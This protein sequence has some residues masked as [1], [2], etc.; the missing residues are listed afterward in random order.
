MT[1]IIYIFLFR[2][3]RM[4]RSA[5]A[6][7]LLRDAHT[8]TSVINAERARVLF[9]T[10]L[11]RNTRCELDRNV[12]V[13]KDVMHCGQTLPARQLRVSLSLR[14]TVTQHTN[15]KKTLSY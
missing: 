14:P 6:D 4:Q 9:L 11:R 5:I 13:A 10:P 1:Y 7:S 2:Q 8:V 12:D 15:R 3:A